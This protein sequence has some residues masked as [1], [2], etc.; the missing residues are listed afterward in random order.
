MSEVYLLALGNPERGDDAFGERLLEAFEARYRLPDNVHG[1]HGGINPLAQYVRI[2]GCAWLVLLDAVR[3]DDQP[4]G[5]VLVDPLPAPA[6]KPSMAVHQ[7]GATELLQ[8][9]DILDERPTRVSLVGAGLDSLDWGEGL[10]EALAR[11][12][13]EACDALAGL[14]HAGGIALTRRARGPNDA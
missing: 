8:L 9:M 2:A 11:C 13:P 1:L 5:V 7:L 3:S 10:G 12:L 4:T 14:L 6:Q